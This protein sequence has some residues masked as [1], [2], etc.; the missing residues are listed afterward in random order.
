MAVVCVFKKR[1]LFKLLMPKE[2]Y[3]FKKKCLRIVHWKFAHLWWVNIDSAY[4]WDIFSRTFQ[5]CQMRLRN[6]PL[7]LGR[8]FLSAKP[9][10]YTWNSWSCAP[11]S[12]S[13]AVSKPSLVLKCFELSGNKSLAVFYCALH[14][15]FVNIISGQSANEIF[16]MKFSSE[17]VNQK[18]IHTQVVSKA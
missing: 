13:N 4:S 14:V 16:C 6:G 1:K 9:S 18:Y 11:C 15:L 17:L 7:Q 8:R 3:F 2:T 12:L 10:Q 5:V